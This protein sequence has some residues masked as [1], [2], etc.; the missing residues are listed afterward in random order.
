MKFNLI[1]NWK[2]K[3]GILLFLLFSNFSIIYGQNT[4]SVKGKV[5]GDGGTLPGVSILIK[6]TKTGAATDFDGNY[7]IKAKSTDVLIFSF[8]GFASKE[9]RINGKTQINVALESE[10]SAL[11][12]VVVIGYGTQRKKEVTG[13]VGQVK[14]EELLRNSTADIGVA[15]QGQV[16]GVNV[17]AASGAPGSEANIVIRGLSSINGLNTP[18]YVVDGFPQDSDPKLSMNEIETIDVLKDA[19]SAAIYG[20]RGAAG[21]ILITTKK[22]KMGKMNIKYDG[23]YGVQH[24]TSGIPLLN[25]EQDLFVAHLLAQTVSG[26]TWN[27]TYTNIESSPAQFTNRTSLIDRYIN[28]NAPIQ[29]HSVSVSGGKEGLAYNVTGSFFSQDGSVLKSGYDRFNVRSNTQYTSGK[30]NIA[31]GIGIRVDE[32][33]Y[34]AGGLITQMYRYHPYQN[35]I[36]PNASSQVDAGATTPNLNDLIAVAGQMKQTD[37]RNGENFTANISADYTILPGLKYTIKAG[38]GYTNNKRV[39]INPLFQSYDILGNLLVQNPRSGVFNGNDR[40]VTNT[41]ENI[42]S[43]TKKFGNHNISLLGVYSREQYEFSS[44][45]A[46]KFDLVSNDITVLNG[47]TLDPLAG[48]GPDRVNTLTGKLG[49]LQYNYKG[50]YLLSISARNDGSSRFGKDYRYET[51]PSASIG[52]NV[53]EEDFWQRFK[54]VASSFKLRAS[55]GTTGNQAIGDYT[56]S[57]TIALFQNNVLGATETLSLGAIQTGFANPTVKWET[58]VQNNFG[59][60]LGFFNDK[61]TL[62]S[63]FYDTTKEDLLLP[64]LLPTS[65][66]GG[67]NSSVVINVG[68]MRNIGIEYALNYKSTGHKFNWNA[69]IN[70][71]QNDNKVT[72]MSGANKIAYLAGSTVNDG[73][74]EDLVSVIAEGYTAGSFFL[75]KTNGLIRTP[76]ELVEYRKLFPTANLGDLR[77][78]DQKTIDT[79]ADGV[80]DKGDGKITLADRVYSGSGTPDFEMGFNFAADYKNFDFSMNWYASQGA[81]IMNGNKSYTYKFQTHRDLQYSWSPQNTGS[82]IPANRGQTNENY[83]G[84]TDY[85]QEDGSFIR[86]KNIAFGYSL[87]KSISEKMKIAR[88][89]IYVAAQNLLTFTKY[90]GFDPEVG[91]NGLST[92]GIDKGGYP[93]SS[94]FRGGIQLD[95]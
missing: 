48:S 43:Y 82:D 87:P 4:I 31:T 2:I 20:T 81:E 34:I 8:I 61:L 49:R 39:R 44:F 78:I 58:S 25:F 89:R 13:A 23:Y 71:S 79:N 37:V 35:D 50:K 11:K 47:A 28:D 29:N 85:F 90:T 75:I 76:E 32:Q 68:D 41:L 60:D 15:L 57:P 46:Q 55:H 24:V 63:D 3:T 36:N 67:N 7:Q 59:F 64:L 92:R 10:A 88:L 16:T 33:N 14:S 77:Y 5:T 70:F 21:V 45:Y 56:Y 53:S 22:G 95:F 93:I 51:F 26:T 6:G 72:K 62:T 19:A 9:V 52:W 84:Y 69:G 66:G 94:Q 18:L 38:V 27:N 65:V 73:P 1:T 80:P 91:N 54:N 86:L 42:I 12:E 30:W 17:T 40:A 74:N 83:R